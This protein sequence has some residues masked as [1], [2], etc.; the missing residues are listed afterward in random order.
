[1]TDRYTAVLP[2]VA[3]GREES[4]RFTR[5]LLNLPA[6]GL[7]THCSDPETH[8]LWLSESVVER[9]QAT[10]LCRGCPVKRECGEAEARGERSASGGCRSYPSA[11]ARPTD[12]VDRI[13]RAASLPR[14]AAV[15][16]CRVSSGVAR[17]AGSRPSWPGSRH[18]ACSGQE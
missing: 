9:R 4:E 17:F 10:I 18:G 3:R 15:L 6:R 5:A 7:R 2:T 14:A 1:M 11:G 13:T 16:F 12:D 8:H